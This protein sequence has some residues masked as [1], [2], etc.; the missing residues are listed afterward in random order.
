MLPSASFLCRKRQEEGLSDSET[1]EDD[2]TESSSDSDEEDD[3]EE[4]RA[5]MIFIQILVNMFAV[6]AHLY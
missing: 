1:D 5:F 3:S 4:G 2:G 6:S